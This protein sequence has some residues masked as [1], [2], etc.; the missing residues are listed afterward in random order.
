M[1]GLLVDKH[2]DTVR[3]DIHETTRQLVARLGMTATSYLA[4]ARDSKQSSRWA[5]AGGPEP[6]QDALERL[7][8]AHRVWS[9]I[10]VAE[11]DYVARN[12]FVANN[13]RLEERSPLDALRS[14]DLGLV[15]AACR[16][17]LDG[18]DG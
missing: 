8:M 17:F 18:T 3:Q 14:G 1:D 7:L 11:S 16:A 10:S 12:W 6:R 13:P 4:G 2:R 15:L 9:A 5:K